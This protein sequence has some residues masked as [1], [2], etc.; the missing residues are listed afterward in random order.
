MKSTGLSR[1]SW[2]VLGASGVV[3]AVLGIYVGGLGPRLGPMLAVLERS[4]GVPAHPW[5]SPGSLLGALGAPWC[6]DGHSWGG[7]RGA[8]AAFS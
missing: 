6:V 8:E 5:R 3:W 1:W 4:W 2:P 7:Q